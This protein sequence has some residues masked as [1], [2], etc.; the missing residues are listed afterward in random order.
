MPYLGIFDQK[1]LIWVFLGQ[2]FEKLLSYLKPS[3]SNLSKVS[4]QLVQLILVQGPLFL[5]FRG[6]LFLKVRVRVCFIKYGL[7]NS[8]CADKVF[9]FKRQLIRKSV[10]YQEVV[11]RMQQLL[12]TSRYSEK[13]LSAAS[14][15]CCRF[16]IIDT[17][18][19]IRLLRKEPCFTVTG[20]LKY[21]ER[22]CLSKIG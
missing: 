13:N 17:V 19:K 3:P 12:Q 22:N 15:A 2:N 20:V 6:P 7:E 18:L 5:K 11:I 8:S 9:I 4:L 1:C 10:C 14:S 16:N 21:A